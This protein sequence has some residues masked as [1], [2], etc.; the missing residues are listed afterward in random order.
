MIRHF[1]VFARSSREDPQTGLTTVETV[2]MIA[3]Y[4]Q[5]YAVRK[6]VTSTLQAADSEGSRKA[7]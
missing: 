2:K 4:H 3:A 6:A 1:T 7:V 5:F